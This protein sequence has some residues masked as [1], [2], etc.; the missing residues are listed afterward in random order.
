MLFADLDLDK[1][2]TARSAVPSL[3][4]ARAFAL[5]DAPHAAAPERAA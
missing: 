1:V 5:P 4:N 2:V 3:A